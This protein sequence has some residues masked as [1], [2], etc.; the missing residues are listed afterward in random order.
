MEIWGASAHA[1]PLRASKTPKN[2]SENRANK[3]K[4]NTQII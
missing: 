3:A 2:S 1:F 4:K